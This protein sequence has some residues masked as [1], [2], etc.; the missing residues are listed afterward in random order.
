MKN[1]LV[2]LQPELKEVVKSSN[3]DLTT[4][5]KIA[6]NYVPF[7]TEITRL[8]EEL[9]GLSKDVPGDAVKAKRIRLDLGKL[10]TPMAEQKK[11]DKEDVLI[12]GR[13]VD[14]L[15]NTCEGAKLLTQKDAE[16]IE[17]HQERLE[18]ARKVQL[19]NNREAL[20]LPYEVDTQYV[21]LAEMT[22]EQFNSYLATNK[23]AFETKKEQEK[24]AEID[25]QEAQMKAELEEIE[26][27]KQAKIEQDKRDA[28]LKELQ[29][30]Q[31]LRDK[32]AEELKPY[33]VFIRDYN[34]LIELPEKEYKSEFADIKRGAELQ[35]KFDEET[36]LAEQKKR[37]EE[38][39]KAKKLQEEND[40]LKQQQEQEKARIEAEEAEKLAKEKALL[41]APDKEKIN[42]L[43]IEIR[44]FKFPDV[45][46]EEAKKIISDIKEGFEI[47]L[48]V[49][50]DKAK[51]LK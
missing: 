45:Q 31:A 8:G 14:A 12:R 44:D 36:K 3:I 18:L 37:D 42:T 24:Q 15:F 30:K 39:E 32:R 41:L 11:L 46:T 16:E 51:A 2:V 17:K 34:A 49:I 33:I 7:L 50:K 35:W 21:A 23:L 9:K 22:E 13:Y 27:Q 19:R 10:S 38:A 43:Y 4:A 5:E 1:E 20:L 48:A 40:K 29:A 47:M 28:E 6:N 25:R 26:R